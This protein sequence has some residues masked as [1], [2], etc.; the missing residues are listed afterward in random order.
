MRNHI[1]CRGL[2]RRSGDADQALAPESA[3]CTSQSLKGDESVFDDEYSA[4][5]R[6]PLCLIFCDN[7]RNRAGLEC[8]CDEIVAI[9]PLAFHSEKQ[10]AGTNRSRVDRVA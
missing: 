9:E 7:G 10:I 8:G 5:F 1:L 3:D 2:S 4:L 6:K